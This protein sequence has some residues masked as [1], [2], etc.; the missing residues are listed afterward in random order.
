MGLQTTVVFA[1]AMLAGA[2]PA[3]GG[4]QAQV[5]SALV[6]RV[7]D[8][9]VAPRDTLRL[10]SSR[11]GVSERVIAA[12]NGLTDR[13]RL[14]PGQRLRIAIR[15]IVPAD[16]ASWD[17]VINIPQRHVFQSSYGLTERAYPIAVG[18]P[19]WPTPVGTFTVL[20]KDHRSTGARQSPRRSVSPPELH[21][22]GHA[23]DRCAGEHLPLRDPWLH[24]TP[25]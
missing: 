8:Y 3:V 24:P 2:A 21:R 19:D 6:D 17:L 7:R 20:E 12:D 5:S 23:R 25:P 11:H 4:G 13:S 15:H 16:A 22:A 1:C 10:I 18:R 14:V 9:E